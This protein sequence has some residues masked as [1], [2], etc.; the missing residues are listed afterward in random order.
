MIG[1]VDY[2]G[3]LGYR[4]FDGRG[5]ALAH[6]DLGHSA[7]LA[8]AAHPYI[9]RINFDCDQFGEATVGR[10]R[11]IDLLLQHH[12][13]PLSHVAAEVGN[14]EFREIGGLWLVWIG[15]RHAG[16]V[17]GYVKTGAVE[18]CGACGGD[19]EV[20]AVEDNHVVIRGSLV[21]RLKVHVVA[22]LGPVGATDLEPQRQRGGINF[23]GP[24]LQQSG[25]GPFGNFK[26]RCVT[27][28]T[29]MHDDRAVTHPTLPTA[30][31]TGESAPQRGRKRVVLL[32]PSATYRSDFVGAAEDLGVE[33]VVASNVR[34]AM[35][36][37]MGDRAIVVD[38]DNVT[39]SVAAIVA[40]HGRAPVDAVVAVDEQGVA[41]AAAASAQLGFAHNPQSAVEATR[42]KL[43]LRNAMRNG[44]VSQPAF[45]AHRPADPPRSAYDRVEEVGGFPVVVKPLH[46]SGSQG[47]IRVD[48]AQSLAQV[49]GR[50]RKIACAPDDPVLIERYVPGREV[51]VEGLM[52]KG[53]LEVLAVFDKPDPL[54]GPYFEETIY[55][56]PS[57]LTA[58]VSGRVE[59]LVADAVKALGLVE[60]PVHAE[61]R[62]D[63]ARSDDA[64]SDDARSDDAGSDDAEGTVPPARMWIIEVAGRSIGGLCARTLRFGL[65]ITL[66]QVILRHAL[67]LPLP[68]LKRER[69]ASGVLMIP[70]DGGGV[71]V[72]VE[73]LDDARGVAGIRGMEITVQNGTTVRPIPEGDRYLGFVFA[74]GESPAVVEAALR[75]ARSCIRPIWG[76]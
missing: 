49:I 58:S 4:G 41:L 6:R 63:D 42:D 55:V 16:P 27:H 70:I 76:R 48:D 47:V 34:Q 18:L 2:A 30:E 61:V 28:R 35:A 59:S 17:G 5:D 57:R 65:G 1:H 8:A 72:R 9:D 40:L 26:R 7:S 29:H 10:D 12:H 24:T 68:N 71:L 14:G 15:D 38:F 19:Y 37:S 44:G 64:R 13:D 62:I 11:R 56:T 69:I 20:E 33:V 73:G 53:V 31:I 39:D 3:D 36:R 46:L 45:A 43:Q 52:R 23:F 75:T 54:T 32:L 74:T 60:G 22:E 50:V 67:G 51:A 66:E 25:K 21:R